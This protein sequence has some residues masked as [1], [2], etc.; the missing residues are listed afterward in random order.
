MLTHV[1]DSLSRAYDW[2]IIQKNDIGKQNI[3]ENAK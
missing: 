3:K 1:A 2:V